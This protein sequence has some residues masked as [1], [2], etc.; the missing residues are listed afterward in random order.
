MCVLEVG[1]NLLLGR[2]NKD[3]GAKVGHLLNNKR[4]EADD[5]SKMA[6]MLNCS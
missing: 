3:D 5:G 1:I 6:E 2:G 4:D